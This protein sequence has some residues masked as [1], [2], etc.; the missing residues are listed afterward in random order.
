MKKITLDVNILMDFLFKREGHEKAA[1]I[2]SRCTKK[3]INGFICAH[4]IT[5]LSYF[6][7]KSVKDKNKTKKAI[8]GIMKIFKIIEINEKILSNAL[9]SAID[10]FED[11]VIEVSSRAK[12]IDYIITRNGKD[13]KKSTVTALTPEELL[14]T[15]K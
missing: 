14:G 13:F 7:G 12:N 4:E 6:L 2:F 15:L 11:A 8:S 9:Y 10:D 5:T 3:E 1:E